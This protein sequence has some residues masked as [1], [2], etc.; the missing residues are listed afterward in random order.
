ME[1]KKIIAGWKCYDDGGGVV[2]Y[3]GFEV[4]M[5]DTPVVF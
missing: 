3:R 5:H 1:G 2:R 4:Y